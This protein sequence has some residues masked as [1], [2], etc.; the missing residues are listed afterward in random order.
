MK[1]NNDK[2]WLLP[3]VLGALL[4]CPVKQAAWKGAFL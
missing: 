2:W 4:I 3:G 1:I